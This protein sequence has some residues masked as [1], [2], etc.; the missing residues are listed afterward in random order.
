VAAPS[1]IV[2][3]GAGVIG[4]AVA[5]ELARR[6]A[7]VEIVDD[8]PAGMGATQASAGVLAPYIE[9]RE[10][11]P[12][13]DL[14]VRSLDLFDK[15]VARVTS[16]SGVDVRYHRTGTIDVA[17]QDD[18]INRFRAVAAEL[19]RRGVTAE[20]LTAEAARREEPLLAD[21]ILGGL[22]IEAHGYVAAADL[23]RALAAAARR[24]GAQ[25][26]ESG[27]VR[28]VSRRGGD[29]LVETDRGSLVGNGVVLAAGS[30][31]S[32]IEIEGVL[33]RVP[34][35]PV[36]GQLL[37]LAWQ[38][39]P[40]RRVTWGERCYLVPWDDG[41]LL[42]GATVEDAGFDERTTAAGVHDLLEAA[43]ELVPHAWTATFAA[44]RAGLRPASSDELP[45]IGPS[46][47]VPNLMYAT[48]HYRNGVLLAPLTAQLV[49][50]AMLENRLDPAMA[51]TSPRR[52]GEL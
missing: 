28:R 16:V 23:T 22:L 44:A 26:V 18:T 27:R 43:C 10:G 17:F 46:Q 51:A 4:C 32:K 3:I 35:R 9:A 12:L 40:L 2:V 48:G 14:T 39:P 30:W 21:G 49:A 8:R 42:V 50:D 6:G 47:R 25:V 7:S 45:V 19:T 33:P 5:Y 31:S 13:L 15:F 52:F 41:T 24:H 38:G 36:R 11:G 20:L 37:Q 1:D 34:I 29:L